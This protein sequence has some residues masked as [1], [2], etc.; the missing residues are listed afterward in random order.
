MPKLCLHRNAMGVC[1]L[2]H[3]SGI[4]GVVIEIQNRAIVH[5]RAESSINRSLNERKIRCV[6]QVQTDRNVKIVRG[7]SH[8]GSQQVH[9]SALQVHAQCHQQR[10]RPLLLT[11][12]QNSFHHIVIADIKRRKGIMIFA[13]VFQYFFH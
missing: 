13:G 7:G 3:L 10:R 8:H 12:F 2:Y 4:L 1:E 9:I 5:Y 6:I 11:G